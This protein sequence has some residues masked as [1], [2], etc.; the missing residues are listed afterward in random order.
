MKYFT[1]YLVLLSLSFSLINCGSNK[2]V[3]KISQTEEAAQE[4]PFESFIV[5]NLQEDE[6]EATEEGRIGGESEANPVEQLSFADV[7]FEFNESGLTES[8][9]KILAE[10]AKKLK[11]FSN[12]KILIQGH[13]DERGT[14][15]YNLALGERRAVA[16]KIYLSNYGIAVNR[17]Y[18]I[19][20]GKE[21][22]VDTATTEEAWSKNR[23]AAFEIIKR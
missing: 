11:E 6:T 16:T 13:C 23:R 9:R 15:E 1:V 20:Y 5:E 4:D 14:I 12:L 7:N 22:P 19:S 8:A 10:H 2:Q 17:L 3:S 21:R 18:T